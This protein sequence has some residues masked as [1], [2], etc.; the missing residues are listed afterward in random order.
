MSIWRRLLKREN[1][2]TGQ[3]TA[4]GPWDDTYGLR[5]PYPATPENLPLLAEVAVQDAA[6]DE[7]IV[8]DYSEESLR[9]VD[10][11][12]VG[13]HTRGVSLGSILETVFCYG[14]Y[15]GEVMRV[16]GGGTWERTPDPALLGKLPVLREPGGGISAPIAKAFKCVTNGEQDSVTFLV[17]MTKHVGGN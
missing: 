13:Y 15:V 12:L 3:V 14:C 9:A 7:G 10:R 17:K 6:Q 11:I 5:L 2:A 4:D 8:L 1:Q 16:R